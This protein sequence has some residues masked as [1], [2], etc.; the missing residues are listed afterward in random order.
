MKNHLLK[1]KLIYVLLIIGQ[2]IIFITIINIYENTFN[3]FITISINYLLLLYP[4]T[5][6][7]LVYYILKCGHQR[8]IIKKQEEYNKDFEKQ[9]HNFLNHLEA[10]SFLITKND[11]D[12]VQ[13]YLERIGAITTASSKVRQIKNP[14]VAGV[15][16]NFIT[17]AES[18][19]VIFEIDSDSDFLDIP[20]S[21][22]HTTTV[23]SNILSNSLENCKSIEGYITI[24]TENDNDYF[25][26]NITNNG[27][28][29]KIVNGNNKLKWQKELFNGKSTKGIHRG[30]G[31]LIVKEILEQYENCSLELVNKYTPTF[32]LKLKKKVDDVE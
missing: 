26:I 9:K 30:N 2:I 7:I 32:C 1:N 27:K 4:I 11:L 21:A 28:P 8:D 15:F 5:T 14:Y 24:E 25:Y 10:L 23:L 17:K 3:H 29:I 13:F 22:T 19:Q 31:L 16:N 6:L 18:K 12:K 20:L